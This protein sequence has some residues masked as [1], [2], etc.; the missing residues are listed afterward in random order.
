M[1]EQMDVDGVWCETVNDLAGRIGAA[2]IVF[3]PGYGRFTVKRAMQGKTCLCPVDTDKTFPSPDWTR[4][5]DETWDWRF[6]RR[7]DPA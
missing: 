7:Q 1:C 3:K 5:R 2:A 4:E 6:R